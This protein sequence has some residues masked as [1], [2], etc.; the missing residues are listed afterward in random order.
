MGSRYNAYRGN[1]SCCVVGNPEVILPGLADHGRLSDGLQG[2]ISI[3]VQ[4]ATIHQISSIPALRHQAQ[5][6]N[7]RAFIGVKRRGTS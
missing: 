6:E 1:H 2:L 4:S 7:G 3:G 5:H